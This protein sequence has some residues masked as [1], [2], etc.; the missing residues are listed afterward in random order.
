MLFIVAS[1]VICIPHFLEYSSRRRE[2]TGEFIIEE[3]GLN[4]SVYYKLIY[5]SLL[6]PTL[7]YSYHHVFKC[8]RHLSQNNPT[9]PHIELHKHKNPDSDKSGWKENLQCSTP[10]ASPGGTWS[11]RK[12]LFF[13]I[14][15][16]HRVYTLLAIVLLFILCNILPAFLIV[17]DMVNFN[18]M[19]ACQDFNAAN[20]IGYRNFGYTTANLILTD[21]GNWKCTF[22]FDS[23]LR[24]LFSKLP[25]GD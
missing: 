2:S 3:F 20:S 22:N 16:Q 10:W 9:Y 12:F 19:T 18:R 13:F 6:D 25:F 4:K 11:Y 24:N 14:H 1:G 15:C 23:F 5:L 21:V 8:I 7:R 17:W